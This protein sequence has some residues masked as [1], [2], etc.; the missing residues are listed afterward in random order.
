MY[1]EDVCLRYNTRVLLMVVV[2]RLCI[3]SVLKRLKSSGT[4][5]LCVH[6]RTY[7]MNGSTFFKISVYQYSSAKEKGKY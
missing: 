6:F 4:W 5:T 7:A 1:R 2:S 3:K